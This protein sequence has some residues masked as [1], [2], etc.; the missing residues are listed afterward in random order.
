MY[1]RGWR[2]CSPCL[3][4]PLCQPMGDIA[5]VLPHD[6]APLTISDHLQQHRRLT[7]PLASTTPRRQKKQPYKRKKVHPQ[8][9]E[10]LNL[11]LRCTYEKL[12]I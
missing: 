5:T 2:L 9:S 10:A 8:P 6:F 1:K 12:T 7:C 3:P 4:A 11:I